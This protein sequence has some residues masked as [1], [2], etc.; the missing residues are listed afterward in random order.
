MKNY[1][2]GTMMY[3]RTKMLQMK[4]RAK[5]CVNAFLMDERGAS[6]FVAIMLIIV[7]VIALAA[8]FKDALLDMADT[9]ITKLTDFVNS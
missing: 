5:E 6:D 4:C 2:E 8:L 1:L 7:I 9:I 3:V